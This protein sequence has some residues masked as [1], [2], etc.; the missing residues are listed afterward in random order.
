[1]APEIK[2]SSDKNPYVALQADIFSLGVV[3]FFLC[4]GKSVWDGLEFCELSISNKIN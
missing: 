2:S 1:M 4:T 3:F